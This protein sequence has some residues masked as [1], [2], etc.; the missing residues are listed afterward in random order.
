MQWM[1]RTYQWFL[2]TLVQ[3]MICF[4]TTA[5]HYLDQYRLIHHYDPWVSMYSKWKGSW[6]I[7]WKCINVTGN[8]LRYCHWYQISYHIEA[9]TKWPPFCGYH[10]KCIFL[11]ETVQILIWIS[12]K[13]APKSPINNKSAFVQVMAWHQ[14]TCRYQNKWWFMLLMHIHDIC[15]TQ[16][17][18]A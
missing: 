17:A 9:Q 10:F 14:A 16:H 8:L 3:E 7:S 4:L 11:N 12:L 6:S 13:C 18:Q 2:S 1:P 15:I 5:S